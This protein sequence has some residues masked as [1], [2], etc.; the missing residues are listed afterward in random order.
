MPDIKII[1]TAFVEILSRLRVMSVCFRPS[2]RVGAPCNK[3][4]AREQPVRV[5]GGRLAHGTCP[6]RPSSRS[7]VV[8]FFRT[9]WRIRKRKLD[10]EYSCSTSSISVPYCLQ[11]AF[12]YRTDPGDGLSLGALRAASAKDRGC[13]HLRS[14]V[15]A[16]QKER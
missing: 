15:H 3:Q 1:E 8:V 10:D 5:R 4:R 2:M 13:M 14:W 16:P 9:H 11:S 7:L 6:E 12:Q